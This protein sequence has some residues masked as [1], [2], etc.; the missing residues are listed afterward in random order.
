MIIKEEKNLGICMTVGELI[1][2]LKECDP[3]LPIEMDRSTIM[4]TKITG[5]PQD[6]ELPEFTEYINIETA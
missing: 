6:G 5:E 1:D 2:A 3:E 4:L